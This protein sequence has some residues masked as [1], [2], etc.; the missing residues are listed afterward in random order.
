MGGDSVPEDFT[1]RNLLTAGEVLSRDDD[2][3]ATV[4]LYEPGQLPPYNDVSDGAI[5]SVYVER[6]DGAVA[7]LLSHA[8]AFP[9]E[10]GAE[11]AACDPAA[12]ARQSSPTTWF[13]LDRPWAEGD[14]D[15]SG[16]RSVYASI[17]AVRVRPGNEV[18]NETTMRSS[19][20]SLAAA[21]ELAGPD[22]ETESPVAFYWSHVSFAW[23][24]RT[25]PPGI[26]SVLWGGA[27][28]FNA[29]ITTSPFV[30]DEVVLEEMDRLRWV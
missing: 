26:V 29:P 20:S 10:E 12:H 27:S 3:D 24:R 23:C 9:R 13:E 22:E 19:W 1:V 16:F 5:G 17:R 15:R 11:D 21:R 30:D 4:D 2:P 28:T 6:A 7:C 25:S 8:R 18:W 14:A